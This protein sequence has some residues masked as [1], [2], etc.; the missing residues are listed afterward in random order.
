MV[1]EKETL[2]MP[3]WCQIRLTDFT[4]Y[5]LSDQ[6]DFEKFFENYDLSSKCAL[7]NMG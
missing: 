1:A 5:I 6:M 4:C 7:A 2:A 3:G